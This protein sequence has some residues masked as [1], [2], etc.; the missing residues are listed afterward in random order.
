MYCVI[1][2]IIVIDRHED[3]SLQTWNKLPRARIHINIFC[4]IYKHC[5]VQIVGHNSKKLLLSQRCVATDSTCNVNAAMS[6]IYF[7]SFF[8]LYWHEPSS[9]SRG[10]VPRNVW[11]SDEQ[12]DSGHTCRTI[13]FIQKARG[14]R[15][16]SRK[17]S[18]DQNHS[19]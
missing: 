19:K 10:Q 3:E 1:N 7:S 12:L 18:I 9:S 4:S 11:P 5:V 8:E 6:I 14:R 2:I 16:K 15:R 13:T 17:L